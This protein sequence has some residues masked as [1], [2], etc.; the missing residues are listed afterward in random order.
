MSDFL[1]CVLWGALIGAAV[2]MLL[3]DLAMLWIALTSKDMT[4]RGRLEGL[5]G[6]VT[7]G[8]CLFALMG[9][10]P[11]ILVGI[12]VGIVRAFL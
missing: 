3:F 10:V 1:S 11:G 9:A 7:M 8:G 12:V 6:A 5:G 4:V 2:P